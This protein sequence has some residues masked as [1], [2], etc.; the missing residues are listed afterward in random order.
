MYWWRCSEIEEADDGTGETD[1][2][3]ERLQIGTKSCNAGTDSAPLAHSE[4]FCMLRN[5]EELDEL[6]MQAG[7]N[8]GAQEA[9]MSRMKAN[10]ECALTIAEALGVQARMIPK[11]SG[12]DSWA[13]RRE[14]LRF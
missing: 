4:Q 9:L 5:S 11:M 1:R 14:E 12:G 10:K 3:A 8:I 2:M 13:R 6:V 7:Q